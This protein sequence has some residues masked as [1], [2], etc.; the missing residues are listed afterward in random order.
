MALKKIFQTLEDRGNPNEVENT[1]P[2]PCKWEN[3]WLGEGYY[4]WDTFLQNAHWWGNHRYINKYKEYIIC[5]AE[6]KFDDSKCFDLV[7]S[8]EHLTDFSESIDLMRG[9]KLLDE[10]TTVA[11]ILHYMRVTLKIFNYEAVRAYGIN[12]VSKKYNPYRIVFEVDKPQYLDSKPA[13]QIC[14][15]NKNGLSLRNYKIIYPDEYNSDYVV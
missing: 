10:N 6:C 4:F 8:T 12:S 15:Y 14:I 13:I 7:G 1:G 9:K 2:F 3:T 5:Q 11:R